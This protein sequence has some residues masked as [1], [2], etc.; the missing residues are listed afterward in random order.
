MA[1]N[2]IAAGTPAQT[3]QGGKPAAVTSKPGP[4]GSQSAPAKPADPGTQGNAGQTGTPQDPAAQVQLWTSYTHYLLA[5]DGLLRA[6]S[7]IC[8]N[9]L[10]DKSVRDT[11]LGVIDAAHV[12]LQGIS[13]QLNDNIANLNSG[14][15][16][17]Y[18]INPS[19]IPDWS[20]DSAAS[21]IFSGAWES[22]RGVLEAMMASTTPS[23]MVGVALVGVINSGGDIV[24][25]LEKAFA[26]A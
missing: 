6:I 19:P 14:K 16:L 13:K 26:P 5:A 11:V 20:S 25:A 1:K 22:I 18:R 7:G 8:R 23:S 9:Q 10:E 15:P 24:A 3:G 12:A 21:G 17:E 2:P 4:G